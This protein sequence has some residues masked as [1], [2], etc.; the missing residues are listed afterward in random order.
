M[1]DTQRLVLLAKFPYI[2]EARQ[3]ISSS[4]ISVV[5]LV[6]DPAFGMI[7]EKGADRCIT[8]LQVESL[9]SPKSTQS[10]LEGEVACKQE[11]YS[12]IVSRMILSVIADRFLVNR[13]AIAEGK[14]AGERLADLPLEDLLKI[15]SSMGIEAIEEG[16]GFL[17]DFCAFLAFASHFRSPEWKLVQQQVMHGKVLID[18]HKLIRLVAQSVA[19]YLS[20]T[21]PPYTDEIRDGLQVQ[22]NR[23]LSAL[24]EVK[25]KFQKESVSEIRPDV[26]PP[27][28]KEILRQIQNSE[29][30]PHMGRFAI[31]TFLHALG[32]NGEQIFNLFGTVPDFAADKT[33]Y[34]IEHITGTISAVEYDVPE[35][36]TMKS[37]GIC[38]NP[39]SLCNQPWMKHPMTYYRMRLKEKGVSRKPQPDKQQ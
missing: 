5:T 4:G 20:S 12:F 7:R 15:A 22:I 33:R 8:H 10:P 38:F 16:D 19:D 21:I 37:Y 30:V 17:V 29:N 25:E 1:A 31:V 24:R 11:L 39:D 3:Y 26:Y 9:S 32:M 2:P 23:V 18:K 27:C 6:K 35:C 13:C 28:M 36:S 14:L 34:Q